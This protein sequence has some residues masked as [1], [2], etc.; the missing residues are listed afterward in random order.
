[1]DVYVG[2]YTGPGKAQGISLFRLDESSGGLTHV[3]TLEGVDS[4]SFLALHPSRPYLYAVHETEPAG[5]AGP[6]PAGAGD[7]PE[8]SAF[9]VDPTSGRLTHLNRQPSHGA[10]PCYVSL[11]PQGRFV[12][13]ANYGDG[14]LAV[15]P[16][17][18]DGRLGAASHV[19]QHEGSSIH[20]RR[21][22]G[23]HA[24]SVRYE[25]RGDLVLACDLGMDKVML[26]RLDPAG[27][28]VPSD[29][30]FVAVHPGGGPRHVDFDPGGRYV[31][32]NNEIDSTLTSFAYE[33]ARGTLREVDTASTLP[34]G[35]RGRN[36]TAQVLVHP[37]GR[38]VYVSNRGHDSIAVF[39]VDEATGRLIP[40]GQEST[41][42]RTPRHF[43]LHPTGA[44][45]LA[46]NQDSDTVVAFRV[47][48]E[49]GRL[50]PTGQVAETKAPVC[51]IFR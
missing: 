22:Q 51:V 24:H 39:E 43:N 16:V 12:F 28:L 44:L 14:V 38:F 40:R 6:A 48:P 11:D 49:T 35:F 30:P 20:P 18:E 36:S 29:P 25:P 32:V 27:R 21:Q 46:A 33:P 8:V 10:L 4:P 31:F 41:G 13:V 42:G 26:Y 45:L 3:Q 19:V 1:M 37:N 50:T 34:E 7:G 23:P 47:D 2:A 9:V 15:F 17:Q 5:A